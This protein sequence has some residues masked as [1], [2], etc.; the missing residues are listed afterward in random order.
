MKLSLKGFASLGYFTWLRSNDKRG[1]GNVREAILPSAGLKK[2]IASATADDKTSF[3][4]ER[5]RVGMG[6]SARQKKMNEFTKP[7]TDPLSTGP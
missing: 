3:A 2:W 5:E 7:R 6:L 4:P 1:R